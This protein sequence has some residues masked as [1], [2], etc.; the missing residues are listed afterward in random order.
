[1]VLDLARTAVVVGAGLAGLSAAYRLQK[2]GFDVRVLESLD[3]PGG[4]A[5][6]MRRDGFQIDAGP[7]AMTEGYRTYQALAAEVG[8]GDSFVRSSAVVG[9]IREGRVLDIDTFDRK[10][11]IFSSALSPTGKWK[12]LLGLVRIRTSLKGISSF[13]LTE[14]AEKD[15]FSQTAREFAEQTFGYEVA[16]Y[17]ID[18]L[19]RLVTG[20]S[21]TR[22]SRLCVLGGLVNWSVRLISIRGGLDRLPMT[23]ASRLKVIYGAEVLHIDETEHGVELVYR[24]RRGVSQNVQGAVCVIATMFDTARALHAPTAAQT[25]EYARHLRYLQL[26]SVSLAYGATTR[27]KAYAVQVPTVEDPENLLIFLQHNK[28]PDRA[29]AGNSLI[30]LYTDGSVTPRYLEQSDEVIIRWA[31][32]R[33]DKYFPEVSAHFRFAIVSRWPRAGYSASPGFWLRTRSVRSYLSE[34]SRVQIAGDI[35]G[36]GSMESAVLSG[37]DAADRIIRQQRAKILASSL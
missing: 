33:V 6:T 18:P 5:L 4:R 13:R 15:D 36:A 35:F 22:A 37:E 28:A 14:S 25:A 2:A 10:H 9:L 1:V 3:R 11:L 34:T 24:D 20:S 21:S 32:A 16:N 17:V 31:Q 23:L 26:I 30:T 29:P 12:L 19:V 27:S 7:D 8:L